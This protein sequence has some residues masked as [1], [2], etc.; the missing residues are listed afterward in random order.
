MLQVKIKKLHP[1]FKKPDYG[2]PGDA[3]LDLYS[4]EDKELKP[5]ERHNFMTGFALEFPF[6]YVA[7]VKDK[8]GLSVKNGLHTL[9]GVFDAGYRGEYNVTLVNLGSEAYQ[10][11]KGDKLAQLVILPCESAQFAEVEEM[12]DSSRGEG[13]FGS[14]GR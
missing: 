10:I 5:G 4:L 12:S 8:S 1:A 7:V 13:K 14:T 2:H 3:G 9:G 11:K 6:G